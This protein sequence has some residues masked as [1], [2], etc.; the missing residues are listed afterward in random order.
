[1]ATMTASR[2]WD[3][4]QEKEQVSVSDPMA[5]SVSDSMTDSWISK[6]RDAVYGH[7]Q[8]EDLYIALGSDPVIDYWIIIPERDTDLVRSLVQSQYNEVIS[9]FAST[10]SQP[11][12]LDFHICYRDGRDAKNLVPLDVAHIPRP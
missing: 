1:M 11:L 6:I 10:I 5:D 12:N 2:T 3:S 7:S 8:V 4:T 9:L